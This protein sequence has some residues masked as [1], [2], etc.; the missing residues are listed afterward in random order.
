MYKMVKRKDD[1]ISFVGLHISMRKV[2]K[3]GE[4]IYAKHNQ[5]LVVT[6]GTE[7]FS[8]NNLIH[9]AGSLHPFGRAL[10]FRHRFFT[11]EEKLKVSVELKD[12][13]GEDYD[14][15]LHGS[16]FHIEYD[17]KEK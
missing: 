6:A 10:D 4:A 12:K 15:V 16:H 11:L 9:S 17:P 3:V 1:S 5:D 8:G 13:L 14:V 2:L 7:A